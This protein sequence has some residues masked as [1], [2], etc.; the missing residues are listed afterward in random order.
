[1][2]NELTLSGLTI[3]FTKANVPS[4][5]VVVGTIQPTVS[6]TQW[7][8]NTQAVGTSEEAILMGDVAAGGYCLIQN[9]DTTNFVSIRQAT[10]AANFIK[11]LAGEWCV[12]R[13]SPDASAPFIIADTGACNVRILRFDL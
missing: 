7:M 12:F 3:S 5:N 8:D 2:A 13:L 10:G 1:M 4:T 11:L 9:M 6:G